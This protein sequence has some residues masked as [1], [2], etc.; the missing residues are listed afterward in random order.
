MACGG[1]KICEKNINAG[2]LKI[3]HAVRVFN[4]AKDMIEV[5]ER[6]VFNNGEKIKLKI[7]IHSGKVIAG[8]VGNHKPQFSLIGIFFKFNLKY[9]KIFLFYYIHLD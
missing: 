8:V 6:V 4:V 3:N 9:L 7:G 2:M 5:V 1:L